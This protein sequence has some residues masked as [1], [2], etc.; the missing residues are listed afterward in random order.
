MGE[1]MHRRPA[2]RVVGVA[3]VAAFL[4]LSS[5]AWYVSARAA[6]VDAVGSTASL[7]P[8]D[9]R[10]ELPDVAGGKDVS[11]DELHR[12]CQEAR[13]RQA[14]DAVVEDAQAQVDFAGMA[15][16]DGVARFWFTIDPEAHRVRLEA[17]AP[18]GARLE[19][20]AADLTLTELEAIKRAITEDL[21]SLISD[22]MQIQTVGID[23]SRN[24][25]MVGLKEADTSAQRVLQQRY[26]PHVLTEVIGVISED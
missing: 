2:R 11:P 26:G 19:V 6:P 20:S 4:V 14:M 23:P 24:S 17:L 8:E 22:G 9:C 13:L 21:D 5:P 1:S 3:L 7:A 12:L 15:F 10:T 18:A 25:V 16:V